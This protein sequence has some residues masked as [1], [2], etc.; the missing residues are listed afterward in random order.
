MESNALKGRIHCPK[1]MADKLTI[2][3]FQKWL[4]REKVESTRKVWVC[5]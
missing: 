1:E 4:R 3:G 2:A 5:W